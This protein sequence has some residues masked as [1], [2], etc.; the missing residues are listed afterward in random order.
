MEFCPQYL[1][2]DCGTENGIIIIAGIQCLF[3]MSEDA[4]SNIHTERQFG[5]RV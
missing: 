3:I 5:T 2:T 1:R 4:H